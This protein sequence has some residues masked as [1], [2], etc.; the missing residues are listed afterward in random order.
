MIRLRGLHGAA[1]LAAALAILSGCSVDGGF[2]YATG[3]LVLNDDSFSIAEIA[4]TAEMVPEI[5]AIIGSGPLGGSF[6]AE[7][8]SFPAVVPDLTVGIW[9]ISLTAMNASRVPVA[10]GE[11]SVY[12]LSNT[13]SPVSVVMTPIAGTGS[14]EISVTWIDG[15]V[16]VPEITAVFKDGSGGTV[17]ASVA[18]TGPGTAGGISAPLQAGYYTLEIIL[19][20]NGL[21]VM[22]ATESVRVAAGV[23]TR[24]A[25][26]FAEINRQATRYE[27]GG[28]SFTFEWDPP[29]DAPS[30]TGYNV[31]SR[32]RGSASWVYLAQAGAATPS[33]Q[34]T[35]AILAHG[36][37]EFAVQSVYSGGGVS[38]LHTSLDT[39]AAPATGWYVDWRAAP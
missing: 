36:L 18:A 2:Q 21:P 9:Q 37:Y 17:S 7:Y 32:Q 30:L 15:H 1:V 25:F 26:E 16:L 38:E 14:V 29:A 3:S 12:I 23:I 39:S 10:R 22:G 34:V 20:D 13:I 28:D 11:A 4:P 8:S 24:A 6:S 27:I 35:T 19:S 33:I 31:Y 5:F